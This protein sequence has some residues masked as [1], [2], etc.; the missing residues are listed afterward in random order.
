[1]VGCQITPTFTT[2]YD[3]SPMSPAVER[4]DAS[5]AVV[6]FRE[7]RPPRVYTKAGKLF[8]TYIPLIPYVTMHFER[9]EESVRKQS[10]AIEAGGRGI[11]AGAA[12]SVAPPFEEYY[13]PRS[14]AHAIADDLDA[15]G[16]FRQ[17]RFVEDGAPRDV[18]YVLSGTLRR[19][20]MRNS[21]TSYGLGMAGVLL[22]MIPAPM[23]KTTV[24]IEFDLELTR[25]ATGEVVWKKTLE[26]E[27]SRMA[28]LYTNAMIYG[29]GGAFSFNLIPPPSDAQVDRTSLFSWHFEA[30]RRGMLDARQ[31]LARAVAQ[32][33]AIP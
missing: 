19:S 26:S 13:Y 3:L 21:T 23:Q 24:K 32:D 6:P 20:P 15:I 17:V 8:M 30:L 18:E 29:R 12:Q 7:Q 14:F 5:L 1:V 4:I 25:V 27:V 11:T 10:E 33:Q 28:T 9:L 16:L 2:G 31:D 22:W